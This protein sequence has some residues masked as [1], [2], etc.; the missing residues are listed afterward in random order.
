[1]KKGVKIVA[2]LVVVLLAFIALNASW[3][4]LNEDEVAIV[5]HF[6]RIKAIYLNSINPQLREQIQRDAAAAGIHIQEGAGL[7]FKAPFVDTVSKYSARLQTY[8]PQSREIITFDKKKLYFDNIAQWR[9][10]N[11]YRF[12]TSAQ[13]QVEVARDRIDGILYSI[14]NDKV[15]KIVSDDLI[16]NKDGQNDNML[17]ELIAE[18]NERTHAFGV[19]I[20]DVRIRRTDL[21][22]ENYNSIFERMRTER[23][24]M[25]ELYRSQGKEESLKI[26]SNTDREVTF[27]TS[28]AARDAERVKG[29]GD[30]EAARIYSDAYSRTPEFFEFYNMLETYRLTIGNQSTMVIPIDSPFARYL[31]GGA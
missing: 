9:I 20:V 26:T 29:E 8:A 19:T 27:I 5:Q 12:Y 6:G 13:G 16:T 15:G 3:F 7:H 17:R 14:M 18:A 11:P 4:T 2:I 28:E 25:A 24:S 30:S 10:D 23:N 31:L 22:Q 21:P 1:M